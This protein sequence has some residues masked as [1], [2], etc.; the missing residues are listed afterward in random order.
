MTKPGPPR[1]YPT[2]AGRQAAYRARK[3]AKVLH[4][5]P[6][7]HG[8]GYTIYQGDAQLVLPALAEIDVILTD[9][10]YSS[11]T[12]TGARNS[13]QAPLIDFAAMD[14]RTAVAL[15]KR[16]RSQ[17]YHGGTHL[18]TRPRMSEAV[19]SGNVA[20]VLIYSVTCGRQ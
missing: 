15:V 4:H 13:R 10:P 2:N 8:E 16:K 11:T 5:I 20:M 1:I 18:P 19:T 9:P 6:M 17:G 14:T 7:V 3:R 12:H